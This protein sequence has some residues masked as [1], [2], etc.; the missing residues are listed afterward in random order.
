MSEI[1]NWLN[2]WFYN[3]EEDKSNKD[4]G[5]GT[6]SIKNPKPPSKPIKK[7]EQKESCKENNKEKPIMP[8]KEID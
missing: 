8:I 7:I 1:F 6:F 3:T 2:S 5:Y 4:E